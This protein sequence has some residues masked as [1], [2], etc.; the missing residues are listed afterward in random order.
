LYIGTQSYD[1]AKKGKLM[2]FIDFFRNG[3]T[4]FEILPFFYSYKSNGCEVWK[5]NYS[6]S[7]LTQVVGDLP[8]AKIKAGF[9]SSINSAAS[10]IIE[11]KGKLYVGTMGDPINGC[12]VWSYDGDNWIKNVEKGFGDSSNYAAWSV[13]IFNDYLYIG[14]ANWK[15]DNSGFCQIWRSS[16]GNNWEKVVDRGFRDFDTTERTHNRYAWTMEVYKN[17]LYV[18]TYNNPTLYGHKGCQ[19]WRTSNGQTWEKV[20]LP[21]G[22]GFG[23]P[24]NYGIRNIKE[25]DDWLYIGTAGE[26]HG[27]EIWQYNGLLWIP[28]IGK[29]VPG[30]RHKP[31]D[32]RYAGFGDK[33][34]TYAF[35]MI[36]TSQNELWVGTLNKNGCEIYKFDGVN[37]EQI[38]G[39][40]SSSE[41]PNGFGISSNVGARSMIEFPKDSDN[42]V[43]G[44]STLFDNPSVC[45]V[46]IRER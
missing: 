2:S 8:E 15:N 11:F 29:D 32:I 30:I 25:F 13:E 17:Y 1:V 16:D 28:V 42:I 4:I 3:G 22:D 5:Y 41:K 43:V 19:L 7:K 34:N 20:N 27:L 23:D 6:T 40:K 18:G 36:V 39:E 21:N 24:T 10:F 35:S 14:T 12:E 46:W 33:Y 38:I 31:W 44:T 26:N 37:W 45:Q 9:G